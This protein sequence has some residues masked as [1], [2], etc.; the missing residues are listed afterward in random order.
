MAR[1]GLFGKRGRASSLE[2]SSS[3]SSISSTPPFPKS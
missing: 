2:M 3:P 1:R